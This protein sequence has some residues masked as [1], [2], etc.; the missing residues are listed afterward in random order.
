MVC[1]PRPLTPSPS[2][3]SLLAERQTGELISDTD[4]LRS[5]ERSAIRTFVPRGLGPQDS[6]DVVCPGVF[7]VRRCRLKDEG[8]ILGCP[9]PE[10]DLKPQPAV[11]RRLRQTN[12]RRLQHRQDFCSQ[13]SSPHGW[14][15]LACSQRAY[16]EGV[17]VDE[18]VQPSLHLLRFT[19]EDELLEQEDATLTFPPPAPDSELVLPDQLTLLLQV[20]LQ[21]EE[22]EERQTQ[23]RPSNLM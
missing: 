10:P 23:E 3:A 11:P 4:D 7:C 2:N 8:L 20:H 15:G 12:V 22:E 16:L 19:E 18:D 13:S 6:G 5:P 1:C 17:F 9:P 14:R 21:A